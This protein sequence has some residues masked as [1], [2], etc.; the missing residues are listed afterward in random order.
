V[1]RMRARTCAARRSHVSLMLREAELAA[2]SSLKAAAAEYVQRATRMAELCGRE[3]LVANVLL[4][5]AVLLAAV[6]DA[7][8]NAQVTHTTQHRH[9][10]G[11][12]PRSSP[13]APVPPDAHACARASLWLCGHARARARL[14]LPHVRS[15]PAALARYTGRL[16]RPSGPVCSWPLA[17]P[18]GL[19]VPCVPAAAASRLRARSGRRAHATDSVTC[20]CMRADRVA[21]RQ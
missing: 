17:G 14:H 2:K 21:G 20:F 13:P 9:T 7:W 11:A 5:G 12:T 15:V 3:Q 1:E 6:P 10:P 8:C 18:R 4:Y 16:Y 19:C